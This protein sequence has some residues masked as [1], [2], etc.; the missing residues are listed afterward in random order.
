MLYK[1]VGEHLD[2]PKEFFWWLNNSVSAF[3]VLHATV[4]AGLF[5]ALGDEPQTIEELSARCDLPPDKLERLVNFL[6]AEQIVSLLSDGRVAATARS[7]R[8][9]SVKTALACFMMYVDAGQPLHLALRR[10]VTSYEHRFGKPVFEHLGENPEIAAIFAEFMGFLTTLVEEFVFTSHE[11]RPFD[12]AVDIGGSH[13]GLL[14]R[15]LD[16]HREARGIV[17]DLPEVASMVAPAIAAAEHGQRVEVIGGNFFE[18]VPAGNLYLLKM[19]LHDWNDDECV[20]ILESIRRAMHPD[21]RVAIIDHVL[22]ESPQP[23]PGNAMDIAMMVWATGRERKLSE[24]QALFDAAGL[25]LDRVSRNPLGQS[26]VEA[27]AA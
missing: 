6:V 12:L 9:P 19:I 2:D 20:T 26:V 11:F 1:T 7:K 13:G 4:Q 18:S 14:L 22:P 24:F 21:G 10:N 17:F 27:V 3:L 15:L 16:H 8:L 5:D 23:D 25:R